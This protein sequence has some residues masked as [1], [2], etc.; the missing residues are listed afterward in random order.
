MMHHTAHP[1]SEQS[2]LPF[3]SN[4][5]PGEVEFQVLFSRHIQAYATA[6]VTPFGWHMAGAPATPVLDV[7]RQASWYANLYRGVAGPLYVLVQ[8]KMAGIDV[9]AVE[10]NMQTA[11]RIVLQQLQQ[12]QREC[13][14]GFFQGTAGLAVLVAHGLQ[15]GVLYNHEVDWAAWKAALYQDAPFVDV[16]RGK[17]GQGLALLQCSH[18]LDP[19]KTEGELRS[20]IYDLL[21][22][23]KKDGSWLLWNENFEKEQLPGLGYGAAGIILFLLEFAAAYHDQDILAPAIQGLLALSLSFPPGSPR[24]RPHGTG[25]CHGAAGIAQVFIHAFE[26]TLDHRFLQMAGSYLQHN[27]LNV[28]KPSLSHGL[29]GIG[30]VLLQMHQAT[31]QAI[32]RDRAAGIARQL[33]I[34]HA[35]P[36]NESSGLLLGSSGILHF[37]LRF[38]HPHSI[39]HPLMG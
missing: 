18:L 32:W 38:R 26:I 25:W 3:H 2:S 33:Y 4:T 23:Q 17:A 21:T 8:A 5:M 34:L 1:L 20:H 37:L 24:L 10:P 30:H 27:E 7:P 36:R 12:P 35:D 14:P 22:I 28:T 11:W 6:T 31:G 16:M 13:M 19:G 15:Q 29:A 9:S 39:R